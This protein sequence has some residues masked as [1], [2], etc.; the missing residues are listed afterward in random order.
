[1][2]RIETAI[3]ALVIHDE[4]IDAFTFDDG[5]GG[6]TAT[7]AG[8][9]PGSGVGSDRFS[10]VYVQASNAQARDIDTYCI[11]GGD[12]KREGAAWT[13]RAD[14]E[15][16]TEYRGWNEPN[17]L[18]RLD[19]VFTG[20]SRTIVG[21]VT[22]PSTGQVVVVAADS[23]D[24]A[25]VTWDPATRAFGADVTIDTDARNL[26]AVLLVPETE[27]VIAWFDENGA[28]GYASVSSDAGATWEPYERGWLSG[29]LDSTVTSFRVARDRYGNLLMVA[30]NS[31]NGDTWFYVSTDGG[32][33][34]EEHPDVPTASGFCR[35]P[36]LATL[37]N[38][39]VALLFRDYTT[40]DIVVALLE[41][42]Y[43]DPTNTDN[44]VT[45][46]ATT[47]Y[48][49]LYASQCLVVDADGTVY[50]F[51]Y[52]T[53]SGQESLE[54]AR[55]TDH[56]ETW[57]TYS[58]G[59]LADNHVVPRCAAASGGE[60]LLFVH[61]REVFEEH[62]LVLGGWENIET[63][64]ATGNPKRSIQRYA[65]GRHS[66]DTQ[67]KFSPGYADWSLQGWTATGGGAITHGSAEVKFN[68]VASTAYYEYSKDSAS[69][70]EGYEFEAR[71]AVG[72]S[73]ASEAFAIQIARSDG[74]NDYRVSIRMS[75]TGFGVYDH[76]AGGT[77]QAL[78]TIDMT[79]P[80]QF[81]VVWGT[82]SNKPAVFYKRPASSLWL[83]AL[84]FAGLSA[85]GSPLAEDR[86]RV[87][88]LAS[89]SSEG[90]VLFASWYLGPRLYDIANTTF[91]GSRQLRFGRCLTTRPY[92]VRDQVDL[93]GGML[94]LSS[95]GRAARYTESFDV[96]AEYDY[97]I[98]NLIP[99]TS[100][101]PQQGWRSTQVDVDEVFEYA[102]ERNTR[103]D[104]GWN[105][106]VGF[107][108]P[109]PGEIL[110]ELVDE[111]LVTVASG[112]YEG[113]T[114]FA[115]LSWRNDSDSDVIRPKVGSVAGGRYCWEDEWKGGY[116]VI[117]AGTPQLRRIAG[118]SAGVWDASTTGPRMALRLEGMD[119]TED[120]ADTID[121]VHPGGVLVIPNSAGAVFKT[122]RVT[123]SASYPV[124]EAYFDIRKIIIGAA[125]VPGHPMSR[126]WSRR[127]V[128]A[129]AA[130]TDPG[131][132]LWV[133]QRGPQ[134]REV[135]WS[136]QDGNDLYAVRQGAVG[137]HVAV[138][139]A[140]P[141]TVFGDVDQKLA[142]ALARAKGGAV[143]CLLLLSVPDTDQPTT[144][145]DPT[146]W[147]YGR[148][149][150]Q[151]QA[152]NVLGELGD[153]EH[154]R[155]ESLNLVELAWERG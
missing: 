125:T 10:T 90:Y 118:N 84:E 69:A 87:G 123:V 19:D 128:P 34:F 73:T 99:T 88:C 27:Q 16:D 129:V 141:E 81:L 150:G 154:V 97:A 117:N 58:Y 77:H 33:T 57:D 121:L 44:Q 12:P 53:R 68:P 26:G 75:T 52:E 122:I 146:L 82:D 61:D 132:T 95:R 143:P 139:S 135:A 71:C 109:V 106:I 63:D 60:I 40:A 21:A 76:V 130:Q 126:G 147:V 2:A 3:Q 78:V 47:A 85:S 155:V 72:G 119:G 101:S 93:D 49:S 102:F 38:G 86:I 24:P 107:V 66:T 20:A 18:R 14:G 4:R 55:S 43:D 136:Y 89:T 114:G 74:V 15:Q 25:S 124:P 67:Q 110:V 62:V 105:V 1:M 133:Q 142:A 137:D 22:I 35:H 153:G 13:Y 108:G 11:R 80:M 145:T 32:H 115:G 111:A 7:Q 149:T 28:S 48:A 138:H 51:F 127:S 50:A 17:H 8:P 56:G 29:G 131:G 151:V 96:D 134:R 5:E 39:T 100:P 59:V 83:M 6:A 94:Y 91:T 37:Q 54:V 41:D 113:H 65:S 140:L 64:N 36:S 45:I 104:A 31:N 103:L 120:T 70:P 116:V 46:D 112:T 30:T 9:R 92:P 148:L 98:A 144:I 42:A 23:A 79:E 152:N